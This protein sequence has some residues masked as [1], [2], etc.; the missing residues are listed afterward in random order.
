[1][2]EWNREPKGSGARFCPLKGEK[3]EMTIIFTGSPVKTMNSNFVTPQRPEPRVEWHFPAW[4][5]EFYPAT[6]GREPGM[7]WEEVVITESGDNFLAALTT[8]QGVHGWNK[9]CVVA[10]KM[11]LTSKGVKF[12]SFTITEVKVPNLPRIEG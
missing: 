5:G 10:W 12:K 1:M 6:S 7:D 11:R 8:F 4:R 3:G 2:E 9:P